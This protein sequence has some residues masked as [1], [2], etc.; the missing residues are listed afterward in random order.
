MSERSLCPD[1]DAARVLSSRGRRAGG[2]AVVLLAV[3]F[4]ASIVHGADDAPF[5]C[6]T[7]SAGD[8]GVACIGPA[9]ACKYPDVPNGPDN[10]ALDVLAPLELGATNALCRSNGGCRDQECDE[11]EEDQGECVGE[12]LE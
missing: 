10:P 4:A 7:N 2:G 3:A 1:P 6:V 9:S 8:D 11:Q 5:G 12:E